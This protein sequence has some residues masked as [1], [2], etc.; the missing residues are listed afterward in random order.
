MLPLYFLRQISLRF[1]TPSQPYW[2]FV[3]VSA[4]RSFTNV[5]IKLLDP[6]HWEVQYKLSLDLYEMSASVS[7]MRGDIVTMSTC[8]DEIVSHAKTFDDNL[9][10]S[11]LLV[12]LLVSQSKFN[13]ATTN[14]LA[15]LKEFEEVF[16]S[17]LSLDLVR[18]ELSKTKILLQNVTNLD[19]IKLLPRMTN[20]EKLNSMKFLN[21]LGKVSKHSKPMLIPLIA[22]RIVSLTMDFGFCQ[23]S[24]Y[25]LAL[26]GYCM[27]SIVCTPLIDVIP[28]CCILNCPHTNW[29]NSFFTP[30]SM[31]LLS[32]SA[33]LARH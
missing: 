21:A 9:K 33:K 2:C 24:I 14:C 16:P 6:Q 13:D 7:C 17:D 4:A 18:S 3:F 20:R 31:N 32:T 11:E 23:D 25:G 22:C 30:K 29:K 5:G 12:Q 26:I 19:Q 27:V 28:L 15:I 8:L 10:A 1:N